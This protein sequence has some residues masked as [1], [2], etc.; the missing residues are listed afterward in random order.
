MACHDAV[1][2]NVHNREESVLQD[3]GGYDDVEMISLFYR[4]LANR[5]TILENIWIGQIL[6]LDIKLQWEFPLSP[7]PLFKLYKVSQGPDI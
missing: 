2:H 6:V 7:D 5:S 1:K 3:Q 4:Q